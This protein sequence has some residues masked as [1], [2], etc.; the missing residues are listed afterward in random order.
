MWSR[1][2]RFV[3]LAVALAVVGG[4]AWVPAF[5]QSWER[6]HVDFETIESRA[7]DLS[8]QPWSPPQARLPGWM[9]GLTYDQYKAIEPEPGQALWAAENLPFRALFFHPG[10]QFN[11]PIT[12]N[13]VTAT[14]R[15]QIRFSQTYFRYGDL[16]GDHSGPELDAGFVGFKL[17]T[18]LNR[19][20]AFDELVSFQ[21]SC[22]WRALGSGQHYG[23]SA[24]GLAIDTGF[25]TPEEFPDFREFW[26]VKP[27]PDSTST[28]VYALLDSP[29][30]TGAYEFIITPGAATV[31]DV[32]CALFP[33]QEI[34]RLGIAPMS[35]MFWFGENSRRRFDDHRP[36]VHDSDG[37]SIRQKSGER[38]WRPLD[39]PEGL[40]LHFFEMEECEGFGLLQRDRRFEAYEDAE[41]AY[42]DRP[43]LWIEPT[44]Q[45]GPGRVVLMQFGTVREIDDNVAAFWEPREPVKAGSRLEFRYRQHW[46]REP[47]PAQAGGFVTAT[48]TGVHDWDPQTRLVVVDFA[49]PNLADARVDDLVPVVEIQGAE[50]AKGKVE[51]TTLLPLPDGRLRVTFQIKPAQDATTL[52]EIGPL[53]LRCCLRRGSDYL[54]ETWA[55][56]LIP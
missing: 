17:L 49:G 26:L 5:A 41:A 20:E 35:S 42:A 25:D 29:S 8:N 22:Y 36:E 7:R 43:S 47:D 45:W 1:F 33:R 30:C 14:H 32:H 38:L 56:R 44:S 13:E 12:L 6:E 48:R 31:V 3:V 52:A 37:L 27:A 40:N 18:A 9:T 2:L 34:R 28:V 46:T 23:L 21:G 54:T 11:R 10:F 50:S 15:Q 53:E 39:N 4:L 51:G 55:Q 16:V 19:P 24:R